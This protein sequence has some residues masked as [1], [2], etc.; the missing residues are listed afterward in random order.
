LPV[1]NW[2]ESM[3]CNIPVFGKLSWG[4]ECCFEEQVGLEWLDL[5]QGVDVTSLCL[6]RYMEVACEVLVV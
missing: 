4:S 6:V 2:T 1:I 3:H 5:H